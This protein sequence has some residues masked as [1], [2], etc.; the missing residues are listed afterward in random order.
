MSKGTTVRMWRRSLI[1]LVALVMVGFGV[2]A[3]R[4]FQLQIIDG[5]DLQSRAID[6]QLADTTIQ[7]K[8]GS[9]LDRNGES[10]AESA[11][12]WTVVLEPVYFK[13]DARRA[14]VAK[15][16]SAIL[17]MEESVLLE[18]ANNTKSYHTIV[19]RKV[20]SE[21]KDQ[22]V[23]FKA[24]HEITAG[25][26][27]IEDYKRYYPNDNNLAAVVLGF[28]GT[29]SQGLAG[30][31]KQ[32][33]K[34]LT[35][36]PGR[37]VTA[38]NARGTDMPYDYEQMVPAK[39]GNNLKLT[40]DKFIQYSL[41]RHLEEGIK[42]NQVKKRATAIVMDVNTGAILG[43]AVKEDFDPNNPFT[44]TDEV[45][46]AEIETLPEEER[47]KAR[48]EALGEQW[49]NKAVSDN[50]YPGSVFKIITSAMGLQEGVVTEQTPFECPGY[51][52][53]SGRRIKCHKTTGHGHQNFLQALCNSCNPAFGKLG[54]M[55]GTEK[56]YDYFS[57]FGFSDRT[58][59]DLP[60]EAKGQFFNAGGVV[61]A[62]TDLDLAIGSFGQGLT[63]TP[64]QMLTAVASV[65][66][67]GR[68]VQPHVVDQIIDDQG[69]V[70]KQSDTQTKRQVI[71]EE[72]S[73]QLSEYL[74]I[75]A[76]EG[77]GKNGYVAGY[78][79]GGK[80]G[81][82]EKIGQSMQP[83]IKDYISSYC[84]F[85]PADD[86]QVAMLVFYDTPKGDSY[87]G[88]FVAAPTFRE[89]MEEILPY[90]GVERKFNESEE[91]E[92]DVIA[93][94]LVGVSLPEARTNLEQA[95]LT[96]KVYGPTDGNQTVL[97]QIPEQ[98]KA[99]PKSGTV[100]LFT[101]NQSSNTV[102]T[103]PK[104]TQ[105]TMAQANEAAVNAG[106]NIKISGAGGTSEG[107]TPV[108][109]SQSVEEGA[110][111]SPGTV[112]EVVFVTQDRIE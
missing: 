13:D 33:D 73:K 50:Y 93:P 46:A 78:R 110:Q 100:V 107:E 68:L 31:E 106:L 81:T 1:I 67:G 20:E 3:V 91:K 97:R 12:V 84:G 2:L 77:S 17:G 96:Y 6:Q 59:I 28:T 71:S 30:L 63:V 112:V 103:V 86:P 35:G 56:F 8:R 61:G 54:S 64:I 72:T 108:S 58:G 99:V 83:N 88:S 52:M 47:A 76:V 104:L 15:G 66:N 75:N 69:N 25:I 19:K 95:G 38:K 43:M 37:L 39:S 92:Q 62:M 79:V 53:Q 41:E 16:L 32:Y 101:D 4:L 49:R 111:V 90:L 102:V 14:E 22:I 18:K 9:I 34:D 85:A 74:R 65:V 55:I 26:R 60:G 57:A 87:Y 94:E 48:T 45:K 40:I 36:E 21:I 5:E 7:A 10:L 105:M 80:T 29:D 109:V 70:V 98:G 89:V 11:S 51:F 82:S 24:E 42:N 44:I 23:A 27:L